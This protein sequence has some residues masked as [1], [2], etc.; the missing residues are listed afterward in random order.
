MYI[1]FK[2]LYAYAFIFK[3]N[4]TIFIILFLRSID[5]KNSE[6]FVWLILIKK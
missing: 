5:K 2:N 4:K 6:N 3:I 1:I